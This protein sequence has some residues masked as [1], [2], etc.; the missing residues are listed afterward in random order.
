MHFHSKQTVIGI[1]YMCIFLMW[2]L[3]LRISTILFICLRR[4]SCWR[5]VSSLK[6]SYFS[7]IEGHN[8]STARK[9]PPSPSDQKIYQHFQVSFYDITVA[10]SPSKPTLLNPHSTLTGVLTWFLSPKYSFNWGNGR[11]QSL[12]DSGIIQRAMGRILIVSTYIGNGRAI[13]FSLLAVQWRVQTSLW[14]AQ[15][16]C[17]SN[18]SVGKNPFIF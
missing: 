9:L 5:R 15:V 10:Y 2:S 13:C 8:L 17:K 6:I 3:V 12:I 1:L 7:Q 11:N 14:G 18:K 4:S 16:K